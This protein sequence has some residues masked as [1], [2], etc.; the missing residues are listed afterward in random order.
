[1]MIRAEYSQIFDTFEEE[2]YYLIEQSHKLSI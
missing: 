1:M 2:N